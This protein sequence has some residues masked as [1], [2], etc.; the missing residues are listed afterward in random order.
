MRVY[1][2]YEDNEFDVPN[3]KDARIVSIHKTKEGAK[4]AQSK[5]FTGEVNYIEEHTVNE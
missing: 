4:N 1:I 2:L 5:R 3:G